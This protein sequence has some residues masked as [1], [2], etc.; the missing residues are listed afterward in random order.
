MKLR[1]KLPHIDIHSPWLRQEVQRQSIHIRWVPTKE[2]AADGLTKALTIANHEAFIGM[3]G[4]EDQKDLLESIRRKKYLRD[5]LQQQRV[6]SGNG[7]AFGYG[8]DAT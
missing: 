2:M 6:G 1:T 3:P 4:I 5:A 7:V 8:A